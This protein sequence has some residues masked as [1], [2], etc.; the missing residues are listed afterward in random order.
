MEIWLW[1]VV[2]ILIFV[3]LILMVKI[4]FMRK[5]AREI[6]EEFA[7][8]LI[9]DTN[10]LISISSRDQA[11]CSLAAAINTELEKLVRER[12]RYQQGD[13]E[14]KEAVTNISH[15][16]RTPLTAVCGYLDLLE[17]EEKSETVTRYLDMIED[18]TEALERLTEELFHYS[19]IVSTQEMEKKKID[20]RKVM[21]ETL[22]SFY[23]AMQQ[24][25]I[26]PEIH[27]PDYPVW[28]N[29]DTACVSRIFGNI[30][31]NA[32]KYSDGDFEVILKE[33]G[34]SIFINTAAS[35]TPVTVGRLFDRFYTVETGRKSTGLGLSI[36]RT[37]TERMGG[38]IEAE[39]REE[40][41]YI[42]VSFPG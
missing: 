10:T 26:V 13:Q 16:L 25:G 15:D 17:R 7:R 19:V 22:L 39:Y 3:I 24:V 35:L 1:A 32:I 18:R 40:R 31:N 20:M 36:A 28:R 6:R 34:T 11:M 9:T 23:G 2:G 8:R 21:E 30:I 33:D 29:L 42:T 27:L 12:R 4:V 14:L 41:L 37:L 5:A 38:R